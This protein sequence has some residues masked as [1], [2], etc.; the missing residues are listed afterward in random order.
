L[1]TQ[2]ACSLVGFWADKPGRCWFVVREKHCWLADK[3]WLKPT[4]EHAK[5]QWLHVRGNV[6]GYYGSSPI[7]LLIEPLVGLLSL[8]YENINHFLG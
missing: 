8:S 2:S 6:N 3:P 5:C 4:N 1:A 7:I